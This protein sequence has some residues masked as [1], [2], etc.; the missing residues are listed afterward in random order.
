MHK[1]AHAYESTCIDAERT[2]LQVQACPCTDGAI[3]YGVSG[4]VS[5]WRTP[6]Y[7]TGSIRGL[8]QSTRG[9]G[10]WISGVSSYTAGKVEPLFILWQTF[11]LRPPCVQMAA[12]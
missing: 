3:A 9:C 5:H 12:D 8:D 6:T 11:V 2:Y 7:C 10:A 4:W 1:C